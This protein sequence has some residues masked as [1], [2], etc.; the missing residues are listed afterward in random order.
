MAKDKSQTTQDFLGIGDIKSDILIMGDKS[1]RAILFVSPENFALKS[2]EEQEATIFQFQSFLNSLDFSCQIVSQSR[3]TNLAGYFDML[4]TAKANQQNDLLKIQIQEYIN[5][6]QELLSSGSIMTKNFFVIIPFY[7]SE[8][9][10]AT[11]KEK[12]ST[13]LNEENF[14][15]AKNQLLQR[16]EF[17]SLGLRR[18]GIITTLLNTEEIAELMWSLYH[19]KEAEQQEYFPEIPPELIK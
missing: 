5:F 11:L 13:Q 4:E 8:L 14:Q 10:G 18:C 9:F 1:L 3:R 19:T 7:L 2:S 12:I 17:V 15:R 16:A 6:V